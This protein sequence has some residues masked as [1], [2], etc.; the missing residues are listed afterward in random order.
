M[1]KKRTL[2][3]RLAD[4]LREDESI[5]VQTGCFDD[6]SGCW[7]EVEPI[8]FSSKEPFYSY[9]MSFNGKQNKFEGVRI[10][11]NKVRIEIDTNCINNYKC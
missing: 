1:G 3:E 8:N 7:I 6:G 9:E 4:M 10:F 11:E 2:I 5:D